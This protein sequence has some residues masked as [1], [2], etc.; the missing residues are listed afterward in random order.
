M[1]FRD[2][3]QTKEQARVSKIADLRQ[4][5]KRYEERLATLYAEESQDPEPI[6]WRQLR[7]THD[8]QRQISRHGIDRQIRVAWEDEVNH[9]KYGIEGFDLRLR[10][11][12]VDPDAGG[13]TQRGGPTENFGGQSD[14]MGTED[15]VYGSTTSN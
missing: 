2:E 12:G 9:L 11:M 6:D 15:G 4:A 5:K 7:K 1:P 13:E 8:G 3:R 10:R 14:G